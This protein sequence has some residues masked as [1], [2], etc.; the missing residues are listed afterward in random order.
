M[1]RSGRYSA[2]QVVIASLVGAVLMSVGAVWSAWLANI[3]NLSLLDAVSTDDGVMLRTFVPPAERPDI[4]QRAN[5]A[6]AAFQRALSSEPGTSAEYGYGLTL[7]LAGSPS[8]A[9]DH[10][11]RAEPYRPG[12]AGFFGG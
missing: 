1:T 3:A 9:A 2:N 5:A 10:L 11:A 7:L 4:L 12:L 8:Q 6:A